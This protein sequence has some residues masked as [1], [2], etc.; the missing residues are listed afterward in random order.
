MDADARREGLQVLAQ[1]LMQFEVE[2]ETGAGRDQRTPPQD[3]SQRLPSRLV[4]DPGGDPP[5]QDPVLLA[6]CLTTLTSSRCFSMVSM[7]L[8][9][10]FRYP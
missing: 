9:P 7:G 3:V 4:G 1:A 8:L 6:S 5:P 2:K 10:M